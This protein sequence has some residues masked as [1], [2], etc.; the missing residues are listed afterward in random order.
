MGHP[1]TYVCG[2]CRLE[3]EQLESA[4]EHIKTCDGKLNGIF[5]LCSCDRTFAEQE[6]ADR[7]RANCGTK[8]STKASSFKVLHADPDVEDRAVTTA[9]RLALLDIMEERYHEFKPMNATQ[10][11]TFW[12][13]VAQQLKIN[14]T[15]ARAIWNSLMSSYKR[16]KWNERRKGRRSLITWVYEDQMDRIV[17][18]EPA[19]QA[20]EAQ[21]YFLASISTSGSPQTS[22]GGAAE[23]HSTS[24]T[25]SAGT[26]RT[27]TGGTAAARDLSTPSE[28]PVTSETRSSK[29]PKRADV[30]AEVLSETEEEE[31]GEEDESGEEQEEEN[32][33]KTYFKNKEAREE[34]LLK[35]EEEK[36]ALLRELVNRLPSVGTVADRFLS[37]A[38]S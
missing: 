8:Q 18:D 24:A 12:K 16:R 11:H 37:V 23:E 6:V 15:E 19:M 34:K 17:R 10:K 38:D 2:T 20:P 14:F 21:I 35:L 31:N 29:R 26:H 36:V 25:A 30:M 13:S 28:T 3:Y 4:S 1:D 27:V 33:M 32:W 7:H 9:V 22:N 5:Y